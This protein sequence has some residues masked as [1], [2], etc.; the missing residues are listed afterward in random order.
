MSVP[1]RISFV[2]LG[3]QDLETS[4]G[5]YEALGWPRSS[6]ST[7]EVAFF[8]TAQAVLSL[9]P[10]PLLAAEVGVEPI[11]PP[12]FRAV[13]LAINVDDEADVLTI[14]DE[15]VAAGGTIPRPGC[16]TVWGGFTGIFADPDGHLWEVAHNPFFPL[17]SDGTVLVP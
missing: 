3:V 4:T 15:A 8:Q 6:T 9:Y 13:T 5:F 14:L 2:T 10:V 12:R 16:R 11:D 17:M 1:A 7:D